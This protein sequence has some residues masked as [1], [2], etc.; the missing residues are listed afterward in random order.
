MRD[1]D[2]YRADIY[3]VGLGIFAM[4]QVTVETNEVLRQAKL[5]L[6]LTCRH[7]ELVTINDNTEDLAPLYWRPGKDWTIYTELAQYVVS[8]GA[9]ARPTVFAVEGNP[10]MFNDV[11]WEI[12]RLGKEIGLIVQALPGVSCLDVLPIQL[13]FDI[14]DFGVQVMDATQLAMYELQLNPYLSTLILQVGEFGMLHVVDSDAKQAERLGPLVQHL[15]RFYPGD[16]PAVFVKSS[17][18]RNERTIIFTT[19]IASIGREE[20][21]VVRGM[22]LYLPRIGIPP[23]GKW[24]P[25][26]C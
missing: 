2:L 9:K 22:T 11:C 1:S 5:V 20:G 17:S 12:A 23:A 15:E 10:M 7:Q 19:V 6:H 24:V 3:L 16:H 8:R 25:G 18:S 21:R 26:D 13:G 4:K 14:G